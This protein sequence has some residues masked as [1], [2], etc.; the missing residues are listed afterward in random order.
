MKQIAL[1]MA[2]LVAVVA[3][4]CGGGGD[5]GGGGGGGG[6]GSNVY[7]GSSNLNT[8]FNG[9]Q[10]LVAASS[11]AMDL[12][13]N[14]LNVVS[15]Y[16]T[17]TSLEAA[18]ASTAGIYFGELEIVSY[19]FRP[20]ASVQSK[21]IAGG[22]PNST[23]YPNFTDVGDWSYWVVIQSGNTGARDNVVQNGSKINISNLGTAQAPDS[24]FQNA[25]GSFRTDFIEVY[26]SDVGAV[27]DS[28]AGNTF[29]GR[30][31]AGVDAAAGGDPLYKYAGKPIH[32]T[33][34][35]A[36]T[37][38]FPLGVGSFSADQGSV[39]FLFVRND[40]FSQPMVITMNGRAGAPAGQG[41]TVAS[42][43]PAIDNVTPIASAGNKTQQQII[44]SLCTQGTTRRAYQNLVIVPI[45]QFNGPHTTKFPLSTAIAQ[46]GNARLSKA[47][48]AVNPTTWADDM[49]VNVMFKL[50]SAGV[51][52]E[53]NGLNADLEFV[54]T[55]T[56]NLIPFGLDLK[57]Q[58]GH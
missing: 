39:S 43:T 55:G 32:T 16:V 53:T 23:I 24:T 10:N 21:A 38:K 36:T 2:I 34:K 40:W 31:T 13:K 6:G 54:G 51:G 56:G 28:G 58:S 33:N 52:I 7:Q 37:T 29:Y 19:N 42:S 20:G 4:G 14:F 35:I 26:M 3:T 47:I 8:S 1:L 22:F 11:R 41:Q 12:F 30:N 50:D 44:E 46:V 5:G 18:T 25:V 17:V 9:S 48:E 49:Q 45:S 57:I 15:P 27:Y